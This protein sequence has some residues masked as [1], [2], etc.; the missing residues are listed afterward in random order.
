MVVSI[1]A[2]VA[3]VVSEYRRFLRTTFR[4]RDE[5]LRRQFDDYLDKADLVVR[6]PY[7]TLS[8]DFERGTTLKDLV[9]KSGAEPALLRLK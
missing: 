1:P 9:E 8:R 5:Q 3:H 2:A 4:F 6:G 7:V